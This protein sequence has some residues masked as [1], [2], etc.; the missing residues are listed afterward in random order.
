MVDDLEEIIGAM[1]DF[2]ILITLGLSV[3]DPIL[4]SM[5]SSSV[6]ISMI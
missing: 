3:S 5:D 4:I 1:A 2:G 6:S